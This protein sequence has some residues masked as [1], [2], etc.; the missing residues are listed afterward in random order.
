MGPLVL[1]AAPAFTACGV[2]RET[3]TSRSSAKKLLKPRRPTHDKMTP[4]PE[5]ETQRV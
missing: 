3:G 4:L 5:S 1:I 2:K